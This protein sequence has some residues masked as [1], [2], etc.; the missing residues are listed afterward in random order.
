MTL[1]CL[2][3]SATCNLGVIIKYLWTVF[4]FF[5]M[6]SVMGAVVDQQGRSGLSWSQPFG[7]LIGTPNMKIAWLSLLISMD[8][9]KEQE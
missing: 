6:H 2:S 3:L 9:N 4:Y 8:F 1:V 5:I 7:M